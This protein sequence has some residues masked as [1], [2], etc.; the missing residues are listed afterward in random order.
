MRSRSRD[1][2][3]HAAPTLAVVPPAPPAELH[4]DDLADP[5]SESLVKA[6]QGGGGAEALDRLLQSNEGLLHHVLKR[7][8]STGEPYEDLF[9]IARVG[10]IKAAQRFDPAKGAAFATYA[11]A[12]VDG[13]VRHHLR[14]NQLMRQ[15]RWAKALYAQILQ[16]QQNFYSRNK[17]SATVAELAQ[18]VNL[19]EEGVLE[20]IRAYGLADRHSY[21]EP[22]VTTMA[23]TPDPHAMRA[24]RQQTFTLPIEDRI[25]LYEAVRGLSDFHRRIIYLMFFRDLTQQQ[26]ADEMG[27]TQRTVS[28]EQTKALQRLKA[29]LAKKIL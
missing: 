7:F 14:D 16:E 2:T 8:R 15:P 13:E 3:A 5:C 23:T 12:L 24:L 26:V 27:L 10:L 1:R 4:P 29:L 25:L 28:R 17:R 21:D 18:A 6:Y 22:F 19:Q 11:V 20:L 9:Q